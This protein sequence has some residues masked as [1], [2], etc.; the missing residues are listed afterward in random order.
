MSESR[1][2]PA[3]PAVI[4]TSDIL[5]GISSISAFIGQPRRRTFTL[6]SQGVLPVGKL[7]HHYIASKTTLAQHFRKLTSGQI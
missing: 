4:D 6:C 7:G 2:A 3:A 5:K 1:S